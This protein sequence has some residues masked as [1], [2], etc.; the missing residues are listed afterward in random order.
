MVLC[1]T[2]AALLTLGVGVSG[3]NGLAE[4]ARRGVTGF[5]AFRSVPPLYSNG[6][7]RFRLPLEPSVHS[8]NVGSIRRW[9]GRW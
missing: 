8:L 5:L 7:T 1:V 6:E 3:G 9:D 4:S 2:R